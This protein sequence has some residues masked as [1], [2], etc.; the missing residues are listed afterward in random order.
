M[1]WVPFIHRGCD[2]V[3]LLIAVVWREQLVILD[4]G[5][6]EA[7]GGASAYYEVFVGEEQPPDDMA[8]ASLY[9]RARLRR[10]GMIEV[11]AVRIDMT[12]R[13]LDTSYFGDWREPRPRAIAPMPRLGVTRPRAPLHAALVQSLRRRENRLAQVVA[14]VLGSLGER[15]C[16]HVDR[17]VL[18]GTAEMIGSVRVR[19]DAVR[20]AIELACRWRD[21]RLAIAATVSSPVAIVDDEWIRGERHAPPPHVYICVAARPED[22]APASYGFGATSAL[23]AIPEM[24]RADRRVRRKQVRVRRNADGDRGVWYVLPCPI[25]PLF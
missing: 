23:S 9:D 24:V 11:A 3:P 5:D 22:C 15:S 21:D 17:H 19:R 16:G 2:G 25:R 6:D 14:A 4:R 1:S 10:V 8:W 20:A 13:R 7:L 12:S 18:D